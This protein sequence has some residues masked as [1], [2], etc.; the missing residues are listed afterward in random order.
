[1]TE[2]WNGLVS[3][4]RV[5]HGTARF[6]MSFKPPWY[7]RRLFLV[8]LDRLKAWSQGLRLV[9]WFGLVAVLSFTLGVVVF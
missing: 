1:M 2:E 7:R 6:D 9:A 8:A 4:V 3:D 5:S